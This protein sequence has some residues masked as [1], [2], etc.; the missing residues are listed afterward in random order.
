MFNRLLIHI[1]FSQEKCEPSS[2]INLKVS[3]QNHILYGMKI[4]KYLPLKRLMD[5]Y[6]EKTVS[7]I[8][9]YIISLYTCNVFSFEN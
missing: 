8:Y 1:F 2:Y 7:I 5:A 3:G 9:K 6:Y 4:P